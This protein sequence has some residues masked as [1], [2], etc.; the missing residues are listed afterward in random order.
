MSSQRQIW[1]GRICWEQTV[2]NRYIEVEFNVGY[3]QWY[4]S[5]R[6]ELTMQIGL[7]IEFY[8]LTGDEGSYLPLGK[9]HCLHSKKKKIQL[10]NGWVQTVFWGWA[11][12]EPT[13]PVTYHLHDLCLN[14]RPMI[15]FKMPIKKEAIMG[16]Y[17]SAKSQST[18]ISV[19]I[20]TSVV[21][22]VSSLLGLSF[23][24]LTIVL[25]SLIRQIFAYCDKKPSG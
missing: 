5:V 18:N 8:S 3:F 7:C 1:L 19:V 16:I 21:W 10:K 13:I 4:V 14:S 12:T 2:P 20:E 22:K 17:R 24:D 25:R 9:L 6:F 15:K 23:D 11:N